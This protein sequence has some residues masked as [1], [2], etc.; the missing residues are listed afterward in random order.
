MPVLPRIAHHADIG[1][2]DV[3]VV[4]AV[5][6]A[7]GHAPIRLGDRL[8]PA[9][10]QGDLGDLARPARRGGG[11]RGLSARRVPEVGGVELLVG[12]DLDRVL[13]A[14]RLGAEHAVDVAGRA[15]AVAE[16]VHHHGRPAHHVAAGEDGAAGVRDAAVLVGLDQAAFGAVRGQPVQDLHLAD[17]DQDGVAGHLDLGARGEPRGDRAVLVAVQ[18]GLAQDGAADVSLVVGQDPDQRG[19][20]AEE[21]ALLAGLGQV[22]GHDQQFVLGLERHDRGVAPA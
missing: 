21:H 16:R 17:G 3:A 19:A 20:R 22:L 8:L 5:A 4:A 2:H 7:A 10:R 1:A 18:G 6:D 13:G 11:Q 12:H 14:Q 15:L 9:V